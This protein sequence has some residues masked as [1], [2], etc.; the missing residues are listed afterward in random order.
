[1]LPATGTASSKLLSGGSPLNWAEV[2]SSSR[3]MSASGGFFHLAEHQDAGLGRALPIDM[4]ERLPGLVRPDALE[5]RGPQSAEPLRALPVV[6]QS[7]IRVE[8][9]R[10][11]RHHAG[12]NGHVQ[13]VTR[14]VAGPR[15]SQGV[16]SDNL[17]RGQMVYAPVD[18]SRCGP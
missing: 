16:L 8:N 13:R 1:M 12:K 2:P 9:A 15:D 17:G 7:D 11:E 3:V 18:P 5:L 6:P 4:A 14:S 10:L